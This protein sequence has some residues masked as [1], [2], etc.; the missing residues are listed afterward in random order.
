MMKTF[1]RYGSAVVISGPSGVGKSTL[2]GNVR[3]ILPDLSFS[4]SCT[5]R[6]PRAGEIDGR[7]YYFLTPESFEEKV[8]KGE[9]LEYAGIF[10]RRYGTLK[11][12]VL[13]RV[14]GG[15]QVLLDIDVQGAKQIRAAAE[16]S[17]ELARSVHFILIAPPSLEALE[18]RLRGRGSESEEQLALRLGAARSELANYKLYDYVVVNDD[19]EQATADLAAVL[20]SFRLLTGTL[21]QEI[22]R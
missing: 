13:H 7:E 2:V 21:R 9:F 8:Q 6:A 5:T 3:K 19:L 12:E 20:R 1:E 14:E 15:E 11:S 17:P 16:N 4:V 22:F 18:T 10:E